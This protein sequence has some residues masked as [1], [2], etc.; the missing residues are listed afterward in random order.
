MSKLT[1]FYA[2]RTALKEQGLTTDPQ[3]DQLEDQLLKEE[4]LPELVE[5]LKATLSTVKSPLMISVYYDPNGCLSV[6]FTRNCMQTSMVAQASIAKQAEIEFEPD[7]V[8]EETETHG[9]SANNDNLEIETPTQKAK[10]IGFSVSFRDGTVFHEPKAVNTWILTLKKIG[11][12]NIY[13]NRSRL[14]AWHKVAQR[15]ICVV[16]RTQSFRKDGKSPQKPIDGFFVMVQLSNENKVEDIEALSAAFPALSIKVVWD[17]D[18]QV[19][20]QEKTPKEP[21]VQDDS[22]YEDLPI[23]EQFRLYL[24]RTKTE[25]TANAYT[26]TLDNPVRH[27]IKQKVDASADS[28][29]SYTNSEEVSICIEML[30]AS[31]DYVAEN[32]RKH[33][34][35][36]ASLKQYQLFIEEREKSKM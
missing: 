14:K 21:I 15:D 4:L 23:K 30:N 36:S 25:G 27:F 6:S 1:D 10:S 12:E 17:N 26:S 29:F 24:A 20:T 31:M 22:S 2:H 8:A 32:D 13:N 28:I 33:H 18:A 11:L 9:E 7:E 34:S 5:Q 3:W 19:S 16:E 35:M